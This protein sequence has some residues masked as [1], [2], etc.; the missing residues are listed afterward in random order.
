MIKY[1]KGDATQPGG[2]GTKI[3]CHVTNNVGGWGS[4]F[5]VAL[6][7]AFGSGRGT[8]E[9]AYRE[10]HSQGEDYN[11]VAQRCVPFELGNVQFVWVDEGIVVANMIAQENTISL[12]PEGGP[13]IRYESLALCLAKVGDYVDIYGGSVHMPRIGCGLAGGTWDR[14]GPIVE[15]ALEGIAV[16]VYDLDE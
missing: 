9:D 16:T 7:K 5:V 8:P 12:D 6:S 1:I 11:E 14:V 10:W 3:V 15:D 2:P 4:G 13:P